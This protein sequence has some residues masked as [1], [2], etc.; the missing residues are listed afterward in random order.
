VPVQLVSTL[1][2]YG[3]RSSRITVRAHTHAGYG[4]GQ[5]VSE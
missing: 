2:A 5:Y 3:H 4:A 1:A